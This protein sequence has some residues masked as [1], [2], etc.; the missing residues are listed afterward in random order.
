MAEEA[1]SNMPVAITLRDSWS[2]T[3]VVKDS[4]IHISH[5]PGQS[6]GPEA[7]LPI[8]LELN[9]SEQSAFCIVEPDHMLSATTVADS[10][11]CIRKAVLQ[12]VSYTHLT[13]PTIYSV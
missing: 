13:L 7:A 4:M 11:D 1:R 9:D 12:S 10:F 2:Q 6:L 8:Q 3:V 5:L